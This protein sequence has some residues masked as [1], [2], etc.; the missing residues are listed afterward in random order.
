MLRRSFARM[1]ASL[2]RSVKIVEVGPRDGLQNEKSNVPTP[3]KIELINLLSASG[4]TAI[5]THH[6]FV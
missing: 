3:T 4:L 2:P 6:S 1:F 5:G